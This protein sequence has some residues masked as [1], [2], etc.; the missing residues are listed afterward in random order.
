MDEQ[1]TLEVITTPKPKGFQPG[2]TKFGGRRPGSRNLRQPSARAIAEKLKV[3]PLEFLLTIVKTGVISTD[4]G[5][6]VTVPTADRIAAA[7]SALPFIHSRRSSVHVSGQVEVE[8]DTQV[9]KL[10]LVRV[11]LDPELAAM[12]EKIAFAQLEAPEGD[13][14]AA[15]PKLLG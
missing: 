15:T 10:D 2:H 5:R 6:K 9:R 8:M 14:V 13:A 11:M 1:D 12:A 7:R 4:G 3:D